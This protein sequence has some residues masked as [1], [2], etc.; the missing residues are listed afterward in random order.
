MS[1]NFHD[2]AFISKFL[3]F[4]LFNNLNFDLLDS[5]SS[6]FPSSPVDDSI[7]SLT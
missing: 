2:S 5:N 3:K 1:Y 4:F 7:A 6:L